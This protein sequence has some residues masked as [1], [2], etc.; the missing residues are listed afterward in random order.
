MKVRVKDIKDKV[1]DLSAVEEV[2][3]FPALARMQESGEC[4]F[5]EPV[6][7][8]L[9]ISREYDHIRVKGEISTRVRLACSRCLKEYDEGISSSYT[10]F[11]LPASN[12][13]LDEEVE[14]LEQDLVSVSYSGEDIDFSAEI[15]EQVLMEI[16]Y[17]PLCVA[18]C[19]GLCP[20]CG[21]DLNNA[22]CGCGRSDGSLK[23]SILKNFEVKK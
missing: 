5:L 13:P 4:L 16:P 22:A 12:A 2:A 21:V 20:D 6:D 10:V 15:A 14:L 7:V 18:D 11:Y 23:F 1:L 3:D 17:K 9:S 8:R 19:L